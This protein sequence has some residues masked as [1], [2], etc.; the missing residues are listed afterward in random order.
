MPRWIVHLLSRFLGTCREATAE[1]TNLAEGAL[2][3]AESARLHRHL[4]FCPGCKAYRTQMET[5]V[6]TLRELPRE[7][8]DEREREALL[9]QFRARSSR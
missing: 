6:R 4:L 1:A 9:R 8:V 2:P 3:R 5:G 7:G